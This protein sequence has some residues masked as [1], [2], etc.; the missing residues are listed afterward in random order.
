MDAQSHQQARNTGQNTGLA[1]APGK[2]PP[3]PISIVPG[4]IAATTASADSLPKQATNSTMSAATQARLDQVGFGGRARTCKPLSERVP[5]LVRDIFRAGPIYAAFDFVMNQKIPVNPH[6]LRTLVDLVPLAVVR[7]LVRFPSIERRKELLQGFSDIGNE[8]SVVGHYELS[9]SLKP[10]DLERFWNIV[11]GKHG[12][13]SA[14]D[15]DPKD[16]HMTIE[17]AAKRKRSAMTKLAGLD[18]PGVDKDQFRVLDLGCGWGSLM[19]G[20]LDAGVPAANITG[21]NVSDRQIAQMKADEAFSGCV[22]ERRDF[23]AEPR[24]PAN[25]WDAIVTIGGIEHTPPEKMA[26][27]FRGWKEGLKP[28]GRMVL[29]FFCDDPTNRLLGF[30]PREVSTPTLLA[31]L[32]FTGQTV[33]DFEHYKKAW[34]NAGLRAIEEPVRLDQS[35]YARSMR[36]WAENLYNN[37]HEVWKM[38]GGQGAYNHFMAYLVLGEWVFKHGMFQTYRVVLQRDEV[39]VA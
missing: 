24:L 33:Q 11:L 10:A 15:F 35:C 31:Q 22:V 19:R 34:E 20:F 16:P 9:N 38:A 28:N 6:V 36:A 14:V 8:A 25:T 27:V 29:E 2:I 17:Q 13:Y 18:Q 26:E 37:R 3:P 4:S 32:I 39:G 12:F 30:D 23:V 5:Q 1:S 21:H 7:Q